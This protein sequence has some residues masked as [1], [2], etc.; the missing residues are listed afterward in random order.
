[1]GSECAW[2]ALLQ[3]YFSDCRDTFPTG[4]KKGI[5]SIT[6]PL[7]IQHEQQPCAAFMHDKERLKQE[8]QR[9]L[10]KAHTI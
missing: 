9:N 5:Q 4:A 6:A 3:G 2:L 1:M 7:G 10:K 8:H